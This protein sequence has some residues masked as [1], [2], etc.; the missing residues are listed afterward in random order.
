MHHPISLTVRWALLLAFLIAPAVTASADEGDEA[1]YG[2]TWT[3]KERK[4]EGRWSIVQ[5]GD[6]H[7]VVLDRN[8]RTRNAPD[9]KIFLST[10]RANSLNGRNATRNA[11]LVAP[12]SSNRGAQRYRIPAGV[13]LDEM[14]SI[15][16]HCEQYSKLWSVATLNR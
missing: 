4:S 15:M 3:K 11:T 6:H 12:L 7:Y 13:D 8:F 1:L 14:S 2:G 16:I 9:L 10:S 5:N